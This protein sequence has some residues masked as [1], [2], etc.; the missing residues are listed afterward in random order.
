MRLKDKVAIITGAGQSQG[1]CAAMLFSKEGAKV[2][3]SDWHKDEVEETVKM[4]REAGGEAISSHTD[5]R[6]EDQ[7]QNMIKLA[8]DTY[9]K[10]DILYNNAAVDL[11]EGSCTGV[12]ERSLDFITAVH[13]KGYFWGCKHAIPE[14]IKAGGGS[15]IN[16]ASVAAIIP[17]LGGTS[18]DVYAM[19]KA[20]IAALTRS[21]AG[22]YADKNVRCN[23]IY[24]GAIL[25]AG[26]QEA[27]K[28][29]KVMETF[30]EFVGPMNR[31]GMPEEIVY[32]A[33]YLASDESTFTTGTEIVIDGG[34]TL[35]RGATY[36][37]DPAKLFKF[38]LLK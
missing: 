31:I 36:T 38:E 9:G 6:K 30:R 8:V 32:C 4:V 33:M 15:I 2:V 10:L 19:N 29:P 14:M 23:C 20:A 35:T 11:Y 17:S 22:T 26:H 13:F 21:I 34:L 24:P 28:N 1:R 25:S 27:I 5:I 3:A 12:D 16:I 37:D 7:V 18:G